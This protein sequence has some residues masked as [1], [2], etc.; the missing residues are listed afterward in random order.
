MQ[1]TQ[2]L[3]HAFQPVHCP[4]GADQGGLESQGGITLSWGLI[5]PAQPE[6]LRLPPHTAVHGQT[7]R[8][9]MEMV[10]TCYCLEKLPKFIRRVQTQLFQMQR[11]LKSIL[12]KVRVSL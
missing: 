11:F 6:G 9:K 2:S 8:K 7:K 4:A 12:Y 5:K 3:T 1:K 10:L